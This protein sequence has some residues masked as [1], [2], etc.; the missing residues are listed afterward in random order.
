LGVPADKPLDV[1]IFKGGYSDEYAK[2]DEGLYQSRYPKAKISHQGIQNVGPTLQP[3]FVAGSPPDVVDNTGSGK[4][5][6]PTLIADKQLQDLGA[7]LDAPSL[8]D[9]GKK[10]RDTL[11][12]GVVSGGSFGGTCYV[13]YY[14]Y[15]IYGNWYS[16]RLFAQRGWAYPKTWD[17]MLTLCDE[18]K[19]SGIAPWT[20]QG[21]YPQY[22]NFTLLT[23]VGKAGGMGLVTAIDNLEPNAWRADAV[24]AALDA[25]YQLAVRGYFMPGSEALSHTEAQ[26]AWVQGKAAFIPSGSWLE[27]EQKT[28]TPAG[29]D[30]VVGATPSVSSSDKMPVTA[31][32]AR[33]DE[34]YIVPSKAK[35]PY[36]GMELLR[37]MLSRQAARKFAE[38]TSAL[39]VLAGAT[40]GMTLSSGLASAREL[41]TTAGKDIVDFKFNDWYPTLFKAVNDATAELLTKR[42]TP[43]DWINRMQK[44][45]DDVAKDSTIKKYKR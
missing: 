29:F 44:A 40:D 21:K 43:A 5:D 39:P 8:D 11:L 17:E 23:M 33:G 14:V 9:P 15:T 7:L 32:K 12:P 26:A 37:T 42:I 18:I 4:L 3:R 2:F 1:V 24:R 30:M 10:V 35:N 6:A 19:K 27:N 38:L 31:I 28:V 25:V 34:G 45:S 16:K 36:G 20:Y 41:A 13:L 22:M